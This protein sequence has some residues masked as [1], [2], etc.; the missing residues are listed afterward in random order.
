MKTS[1]IVRFFLDYNNNVV[2]TQH[3]CTDPDCNCVGGW[4]EGR[5]TGKSSKLPPISYVFPPIDLEA[6]KA[7]RQSMPPRP[8][9][10]SNRR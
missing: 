3:Q 1:K 4:I 2:G 9:R 10:P 6:A 5:E 7:V 8:H